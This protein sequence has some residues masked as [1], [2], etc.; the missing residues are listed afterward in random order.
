MIRA[1]LV[2]RSL[3]TLFALALGLTAV[4]GCQFL[5]DDFGV[6]P[7]PPP[8]P[9]IC[10][11]RAYR[12]SGAQ[13]ER[14]S[15]DRSRWELVQQCASESE[16]NLNSESCRPCTLNELQCK[17][18]EL[19]R[20]NAS[21][22]WD[23]VAPC[24][25]AE[26]CQESR[27]L[28]STSC[29]PPVCTAGSVRCHK[30]ELLR[31]GEGLDRF[32]SAGLCATPAL[33]VQTLTNNP[34]AE[35]CDPPACQ[36]DEYSCDGSL[37]RRCNADRTGWDT[38][39]DCGSTWSCSAG[40]KACQPCMVGSMECNHG[41]LRRCDASGEWRVTETC[42]TPTLCDPGTL[43]CRSPGCATVG[44][45]RCLA[46]GGVSELQECGPTRDWVRL[47]TCS[48]AELCDPEKRECEA[49]GCRPGEVRCSGDALQ[50]CNSDQTTFVT[51]RV[52]T[53]GGCSPLG[54]GSCNAA[55][56]STGSFRCNN[57]HF[58]ECV[59][60]IWQHRERCLTQELCNPGPVEAGC[61]KPACG[62]TLGEFRCQSMNLDVCA[63]GRHDWQFTAGCRTQADCD[64]GPV[65]PNGTTPDAVFGFGSGYCRR[66]EPG[67]TSC[68]DNS[69][70]VCPGEPAPSDPIKI[71]DC[72]ASCVSDVA[73]ARC[74]P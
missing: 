32:V 8:L 46:M 60:G 73:G 9:R 57:L 2:L 55:V 33:C 18:A 34:Q 3:R 68:Q 31:C 52:C 48:T 17:D 59:D 6:E 28:D 53:P 54:S 35:R 71:A 5:F 64:P 74:G 66:C 72:A 23:S 36:P 27:A 10:P 37:L 65:I 49:E 38:V 15:D 69:L 50:V 21:A 56:C 62:G 41:D 13:L 39:Q 70:Y 16:C 19:L 30:A 51:L 61:R 22:G 40:A 25:S 43:S 44:E 42:D 58:E 26:L 24:A 4:S 47:D 11:S 12:C 45:R 67:T 63:D 1:S 20:C 14:C 29:V 7:A